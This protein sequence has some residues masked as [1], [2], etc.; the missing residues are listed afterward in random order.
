MLP[1]TQTAQK[2]KKKQRVCR[3]VAQLSTG[4]L[5]VEI[6]DSRGLTRYY[7][8]ECPADFGRGFT[9]RKAPAD[10]PTTY[11]VNLGDRENAPSCE[12]KG[13][14]QFGHRTT[15]RHLACIRTLLDR[16]FFS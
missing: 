2:A 16:G 6:E 12:C 1:T 7:V 15:C 10:N 5:V 4:T 13:H 11:H 9:F 8:D 14:L 3:V